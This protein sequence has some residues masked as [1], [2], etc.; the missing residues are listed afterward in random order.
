M[1]VTNHFQVC[2]KI[3]VIDEA[4]DSVLLAKRYGEADYDG[5]FSFIGGKLENADG[6][7]IDGLRREKNEEIGES[8]KLMVYPEISWNTYY[9][10]KDGN[11]MFLPH[12]LALYKGGDIL[13]NKEEYSEYDW[14]KLDEL[15]EFEPKINTI[16]PAVKAVLILKD[17]ITVSSLAIEI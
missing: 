14:V 16:A 7:I 13:L 5:V 12:Y 4:A 11:S 9:E 10:K 1:S 6:G 8:A 15:E 3:I 2:Q 17:G